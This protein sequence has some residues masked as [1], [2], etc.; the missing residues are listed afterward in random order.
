MGVKLT[1]DLQNDMD[2]GAIEV[3]SPNGI[4]RKIN[5]YQELVDTGRFHGFNPWA[6]AKSLMSMYALN[7]DRP[8]KPIAQ[9]R[10]AKWRKYIEVVDSKKKYKCGE[11]GWIGKVS[12]MG[13]G[14]HTEFSCPNCTEDFDLSK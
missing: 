6:C 4:N 14:L 12:E 3:Y 5:S 7:Y 9:E 13:D 1:Y 11:C 8:E 2:S 10:L